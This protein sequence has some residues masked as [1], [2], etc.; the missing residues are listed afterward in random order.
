MT[1]AGL[2]DRW[3]AGES[4]DG[5]AYAQGARVVLPDGRLG[6]VLLLAGP[7]PDPPYLVELPDAP[8]PVRL[9]QS[10]LTVV[11]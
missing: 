7:P 9:R 6:R 1:V 8:R 4:I 2:G 3:L 5:V 10:E 11:Q